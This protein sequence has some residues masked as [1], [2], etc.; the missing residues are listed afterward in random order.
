MKNI[1]ISKQPEKS[2]NFE[3]LI[4]I[5]QEKNINLIV[6]KQGD[7]IEIEK[8]ITMRI[9]WPNTESVTKN[10]LNNN[11]IVCKINY[12]DFSVLFTGDI[13]KEAE[14]ALINSLEKDTKILNADILKVAHHGSNTSSTEDLIRKIHP[15]Y[16]LIGV[17]ENNK[18]G[19]PNNDVIKRLENIRI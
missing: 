2:K 5:A 16:A 17:G 15:K 6:V 8:D 19:H 1:I 3:K 12:K 18:F 14:N 7:V 9:L 13:E 10:T 11:S 4:R